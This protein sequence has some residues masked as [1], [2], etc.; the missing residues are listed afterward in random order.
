MRRIYSLIIAIA[1]IISMFTSSAIISYAANQT[2]DGIKIEGE[3]LISDIDGIHTRYVV[4]AK[5][6][7]DKDLSV[8]AKFYALKA[9]GNPV[10]SVT[11][12]ASAV[13]KGQSFMLYGQFKNSDIEEATEFS[14]EITVKET[15]NCR[16]DAVG[17][18]VEAG[19][20]SALAVTGTNYSSEDV[21]CINVRSIFFKN[22][23]AVAF[24]TVNIGDYG[25]S[26]RSGSSN[27]QEIG[28]LLPE[29]DDYLV[30]YSVA[31]DL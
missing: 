30:T 23:E 22:G 21:G 19:I 8:I 26:L 1:V 11:D 15:D 9:N 4:V 31:S 24:D 13:K 16:Y 2:A 29:Y 20:D 12:G 5:N 28:M 14:Y 18:D 17:F 27:T 3:Y 25:Y 7:S 10:K 6:V